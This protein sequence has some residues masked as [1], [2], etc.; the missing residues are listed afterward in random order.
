MPMRKKFLLVVT[1]I[2]LFVSLAG[3]KSLLTNTNLIDTTYGLTTSNIS[4]Y[5]SD[6][7]SSPILNASIGLQ[8]TVEINVDFTYSYTQQSFNFWGSSS[9]TVTQS[10]SA[11]ASGFF[12]NTDGY[13]LTNAHVVTLEDYE[14]LPDFQYLK[15]SVTIN[16]ADSQAMIDATVVDY[17]QSLDLA[18]LKVDTTQLTNIQYLTFYDLTDPNDSAYGTD[19]AV[20]LLYGEPVMAIGNANGYGLSVTEGVVSAPLRYFTNSDNSVT[21]AIQTDT[22]ISPG[23]S[24]GPLLN[25]YAEVIGIISFKIVD[26]SVENI[27]YAIPTYVILSYISGFD[28]SITYH[29]TTV[30]AYS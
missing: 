8:A 29:T 20:M 14:S 3:C 24:G 27:G 5:I 22:A 19:Q 28:Q 13:I 9:Q 12:I 10:V 21:R 16:Y 18:L 23:N 2:L 4:S 26:S 15:T 25:A 17:N 1:L 11:K 7:N 30:R 6:A